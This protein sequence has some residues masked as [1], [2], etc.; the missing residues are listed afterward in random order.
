M[1]PQTQDGSARDQNVAD[2]GGDL[3]AAGGNVCPRRDE[4]TGAVLRSFALAAGVLPTCEDEPA[5][6][7]AP[8]TRLL[9][10]S[11]PRHVF[12]RHAPLRRRRTFC[13]YTPSF[14][15]FSADYTPAPT[16]CL[17]PIRPP[18][19]CFRSDI[20]S[21]DTLPA[22]FKTRYILRRGVFLR[23]CVVSLFFTKRNSNIFVI[24]FQHFLSISIYNSFQI[25]L[26]RSDS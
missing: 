1:Q 14:D 24:K 13:R 19:T 20:S 18:P 25:Y 8:P 4:L 10:T 21:T 11:L 3:K 5:G 23:R 22:V 15:A 9:P 12:H 6:V 2:I 17:P 26:E 7:P 16:T